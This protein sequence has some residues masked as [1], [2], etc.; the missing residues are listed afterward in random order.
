MTVHHAIIELESH[1]R[2]ASFINV[3]DEVRA[4]IAESGITNGLVA[5]T[6][7][8]TT[9]SVYYDEYA[10]DELDDGTDFLQADLNDALAQIV[11]DQ[12]EL[13]PAGHYRYPGEAHFRDVESWPDADAYLPG[14]DRTQLLNADAHIKASIM[15]S[16]QVFPLVQGRLG[17]GV[18]GYIFFTDWDRSRA[19]KRK[20]HVTIIGE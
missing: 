4:I 17:F 6:S 16:S 12:D 13:P 9:C 3:T 1:G 5:V 8:H 14:G 11:P 20:C 15:G 10:H 18:T 2:T 7:P 19:R